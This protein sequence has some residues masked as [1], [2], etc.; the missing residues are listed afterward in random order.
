MTYRLKLALVASVVSLLIAPSTW[1]GEISPVAS[2]KEGET[3]LSKVLPLKENWGKRKI[4]QLS[5]FKTP[6]T[7]AQPLLVQTPSQG[8]QVTSI[9]GVKANATDKGVEVILQTPVGTRLQLTNRSTGN[10]FIVDVSGGQLR[11][12][13]GEVFTFRSEKPLAGITAITVANIDATTVR[14]TVV[15]EKA[16]PTVELFDDDTGLVFAVASTA[17]AQQ[18]PQT[19]QTEE[20]PAPRTPQESPAAQQDEPIELVVTGEADSYRVQEATTATRTDTPLRDIPQ[21]IQVVPQQLLEDRNVRNPIEALE[22]VS[23]VVTGDFYQGV[24]SAP[25]FIIRGFNQQ[26]NFRNGFRDNNGYSLTGIETVEQVEVLKGPASVLFGAVEPG[27]I[28]NFITKQPLSEPYYKIGFEAGSFGFYQPNIDFSGP[29]NTEKNLLYR[30]IVGYQSSDS[31][32]DFTNSYL[33]TIAPSITWKLGDRTD[34]NLYYEYNKYFANPS[35]LY[36]GSLSDGSFLPQNLYIGY[37]DTSFINITT[38]KFGYTFKHQF[39]DNWQIRNNF[40]VSASRT[41]DEGNSAGA[42]VDDRFLEGI[43]GADSDFTIDNYFGQA[44]L[45]GKFN[46]GSISHQLLLGFDVNRNAQTYKSFSV[47]GFPNL[48]ILNPNYNVTKPEPVF[49]FDNNSYSQSY[50]IY[51]Q[52][53]IALQDNLKLL[54]G[55]RYDWVD[56]KIIN[57]VTQET[58]ENPDNSAFSPRIGLVYQPS[59]EIS[60]YT[61]YS[62]SFVPNNGLKPDGEV[63]VPTRGTQY[64]AGIKTDLLDNRLSATLAAYQITKSNVLVPDPDPERAR[65][66]YQIQIGEQRSRGIELDITGEILPGLKVTASYAYT[67][68]EVTEDT[69]PLNI[70]ERL[71]GVPENQASLWTTYEIQNGNLKGL[72]FGLGLF[73]IGTRPG[74]LPNTYT[75]EDYLRTDAAIYYRKGGFNAAINIHNLFDT[76]YVLTPLFGSPE[77]G[78]FFQRG[79]PL[80]IVGSISWEF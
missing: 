53:Q 45:L 57:N 69:D 3:G 77:T 20:Q 48:D 22:T 63:F 70:G 75:V 58:T 61:S 2:L 71:R 37:S 4:R 1:A 8:S 16:L 60:L 50:G 31:Y 30:L 24:T 47:S 56:S 43:G 44:D 42:L 51:L 54:V 23:G 28:V 66:R 40:S 27:G 33:L 78:V 79:E 9:T 15:G 13:S 62:R 38:E 14:V 59:K 36:T 32:Q 76:E 55:G 39:S 7:N 49:S 67:N 6:I 17:T 68:A 35:Q 34:L 21:S 73:Y 41:I 19:P 72:G 18:P 11:L 52:D 26:G 64:E 74:D 46:T 5:D 10:N 25:S 80:T 29:L 12:P 65:D